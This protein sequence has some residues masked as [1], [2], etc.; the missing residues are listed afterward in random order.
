MQYFSSSD[1]NR[2][3]A[4][5]YIE[6]EDGNTTASG[7]F[8]KFKNN[9]SIFL[10]TN[11]HV[12]ENAKTLTIS[13]H[14]SIKETC[15]IY[16]T[17]IQ[18]Q[19]ILHPQSNVDLCV[20]KINEKNVEFLPSSI[21]LT[22]SQINLI[23]ESMI[24]TEE[25]CKKLNYCEDVIMF[26]A[27]NTLYDVKNNLSIS[28]RGMTST[29]AGS[30]FYDLEQFIVDI[31]SYRGSS[32]SAIY[33]CTEKTMLNFSNTKLLGIY[34]KAQYNHHEKNIKIYIHL[35]KAVNAYKLLEFKDLI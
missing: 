13:L 6:K 30:K 22:N 23:E 1:L 24:V 20:I 27:P 14:T 21:N 26:G 2:A 8:F 34:S 3:T 31:P 4:Y 10:V 16:M 7:F 33:L 12:I 9:D 11:K 15:Y 28:Y 5:I 17:D 35:G 29:H 19:V 32:G 18:N 25:E